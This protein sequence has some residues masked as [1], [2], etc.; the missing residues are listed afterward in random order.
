MVDPL[1][2]TTYVA[3]CS[4]TPGPNNCMALAYAGAQG[5]RKGP[6]FSGGVF[7]GMLAVMLACAA[8]GSLLTSNLQHAQTFM[9]WAGAAYMAWLAWSVLRSSNK[10]RQR[11]NAAGRVFISGGVLQLL[12]VKVLIYGLTA[13]SAF[14]LP[15]Y[16]DP[17]SLLF[18]A[19]LLALA[20]FIGTACW[21]LFG[22]A[23]EAQFQRRPRLINRTLAAL[24][25]YC[26]VSML[27]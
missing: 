17:L 7:F 20:G 4:I 19:S 14:I 9:K 12:N 25:A 23:L 26:A 6:L 2:F 16:R 8:A 3:I 11:N 24:L 13:F 10:T 15:V 5:Q 22:A 21:A 18:F 1:A 27:L